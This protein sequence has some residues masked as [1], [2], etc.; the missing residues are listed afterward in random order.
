MADKKTKDLNKVVQSTVPVSM[1]PSSTDDFPLVYSEDIWDVAAD[2]SNLAEL[3]DGY[4]Q[5][6]QSDINEALAGNSGSPTPYELPK[7]TS[8]T[9]TYRGEK[10]EGLSY[11]YN[12]LTVKITKGT[13]DIA[14]IKF[15]VNGVVVNTN[16]SGSTSITYRYEPSGGIYKSETYKV[17]VTDTNNYVVESEVELKFISYIYLK[18]KTTPSTT[19]PTTSSNIHYSEIQ[20]VYSENVDLGATYSLQYGAFVSCKDGYEPMIKTNFSDNLVFTSSEII[21]YVVSGNIKVPYIVWTTTSA[22]LNNSTYDSISFK[23]CTPQY[24]APYIKGSYTNS[25]NTYNL[26]LNSTYGTPT[27]GT[28]KAGTYPL[29]MTDDT[30]F[31]FAWS[32]YESALNNLQ[33]NSYESTFN[34]TYEDEFKEDV[35]SVDI[36]YLVIYVSPTQLTGTVTQKRNIVLENGT[37]FIYFKTFEYANLTAYGNTIYDAENYIYV[38]YS[39]TSMSAN[40]YAYDTVTSETYSL[41][42]TYSGTILYEY[43]IGTNPIK[44]ERITSSYIPSF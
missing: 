5:Y 31:D 18:R 14:N 44:I 36:P 9:S 33:I 41:T 43:K 2:G 4:G 28:P 26:T 40:M 29:T 32:T 20:K 37:K 24:L 25:S 34:C 1:K 27:Y 15:Y 30:H 35:A 6:S 13:A 42:K 3:M 8:F 22:V 12:N 39:N 10:E 11:A 21:P 7:I 19:A 23:A 38:A 16:T 17:E